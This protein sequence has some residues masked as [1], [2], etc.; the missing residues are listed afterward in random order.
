M[1][2]LYT[3]RNY[4]LA[5]IG[6]K[7]F[8]ASKAME[9]WCYGAEKSKDRIGK[10]QTICG[11]WR[12]CMHNKDQG[13][14]GNLLGCSL[15]LELL[16]SGILVFWVHGLRIWFH[17]LQGLVDVTWTACGMWCVVCGM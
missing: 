11:I 1:L 15:A 9:L 8:G 5:C 17:G 7:I 16:G 4:N 10:A 14:L 6:M 2:L 12:I 13:W 3:H